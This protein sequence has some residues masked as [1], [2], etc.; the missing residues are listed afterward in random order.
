MSMKKLEDLPRKNIFEVP[1]GYF[2]KL[3]GIIQSRVT[4]GEKQSRPAFSFA[5]RLALPF[6]LLLAIV[7][8]FL[9]NQPETDA[10]A[11]SILASVQTKD[12]VAYLSEADFTTDELLDYVELD[13]EDVTQIE[14]S[15]YEFQLNDPDIEDILNE[16]EP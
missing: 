15:V 13:G 2:E 8:A 3:P 12:L 1:D 9:L 6:V 11:Q 14:E 4:G 10:N 16:V 5:L 7:A